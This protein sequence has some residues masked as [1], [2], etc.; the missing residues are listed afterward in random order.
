[1]DLGESLTPE[2]IQI[3]TSATDKF[4]VLHDIARLAKTSAAL[5]EYAEEVIYEALDSRERIGSTGFGRRIAIPH[6]SFDEVDGFV[7]GVLIAPNGIDFDSLDGEK[8]KVFFF[9]IGPQPQRNKHIQ[10]LSTVSKLLE[11]EEL[12]ERLIAADTADTVLKILAGR[13]SVLDVEKSPAQ[14]SMFHVCVQREELFSDVLQLFA[15]VNESSLAVIETR[16][17]STYLHS[18][19]L[20][21]AFWSESGERPGRIIIAYVDKAMANDIIRRLHLIAG[22]IEEE[23][24]L[25][26]AVQDLTYFAGSLDF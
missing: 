6:C 19:P 26:V 3:G 12:V 22:D 20:F 8:T 9:I 10:I 1:M 5:E 16:N 18:L 25:M 21:S 14:K 4:D 17:A 23:S 7:V 24:G 11:S 15:S 2:R 13:L